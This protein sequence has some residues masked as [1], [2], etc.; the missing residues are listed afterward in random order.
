MIDLTT[1]PIN[2][3]ETSL[4]SLCGQTYYVKDVAHK[5]RNGLGHTGFTVVETAQV[6]RLSALLAVIRS[7]NPD[8]VDE[9]LH[10]MKGWK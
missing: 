4:K 6:G 5:I 2:S 10:I 3:I 8:I 7:E 1:N 9:A